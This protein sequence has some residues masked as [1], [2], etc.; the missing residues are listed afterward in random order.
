MWTIFRYHKTLFRG[1]FDH[2]FMWLYNMMNS[3][4]YKT[5]NMTQTQSESPNKIDPKHKYKK[6]AF[7]AVH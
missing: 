3:A 1:G 6:K 4:V 7:L 2:L 5:R